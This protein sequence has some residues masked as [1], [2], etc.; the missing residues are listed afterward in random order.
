MFFKK[1]K[2]TT[3]NNP[4][5]RAVN[6]IVAIVL[7]LAFVSNYGKTHSVSATKSTEELKQS[8]VNAAPQLPVDLSNY[9]SLLP[10]DAEQLSIKDTQPGDG[11]EAVCGQ[12]V[13]IAYTAA[14]I[15][16]AAI[17]DSASKDKPLTF[18]IGDGKAMQAF[19]QGVAGMAKGGHRL[20]FAPFDAAYGSKGFARSDVPAGSRI[21][22]DVELLD[23]TPPLPE[24]GAFRI[25]EVQ[26]G[27]GHPI[28]CGSPA[29]LQLVVWDIEG[30]KLFSTLDAGHAP[31]IVTPGTSSIFLGL[32]L[33]I[34][35]MKAG[36]KRTLIVPPD[37]QKIM[38]GND[39]EVVF[40]FPAKQ[41]VLVDVEVTPDGR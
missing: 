22:F 6:W 31:L 13:S 15:E 28:L 30:K 39:P 4:N 12:R 35:G 37:F 2:K 10:G 14:T 1:P 11:P 16:R 36:E 29:K 32:E 27:S 19:E 38:N 25:I 8:L 26:K 24:A 7:L 33:G 41:L 21:L 20:I 18:T 9:K 5:V 23:V 34:A 17:A 40:P 3:P